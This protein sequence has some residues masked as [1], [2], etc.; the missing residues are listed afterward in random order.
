MV[1]F[2]RPMRTKLPEGGFPTTPVDPARIR[3]RDEQAKKYMKKNADTKAYVKP[4]KISKGDQVIVRRDPSH[5]KSTTPYDPT[6]YFVTERKGSMVTASRDDKTIT[7]NSSF[8]KP[9]SVEGEQVA[10][11]P[12]TVEMSS[13]GQNE[14]TSRRYPLRSSRRPPERFKDYVK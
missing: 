5:K 3:E 10:E 6:L 9:I 13:D 8:F 14:E 1:L 12:Q 7:R 2:N 11:S 4:S